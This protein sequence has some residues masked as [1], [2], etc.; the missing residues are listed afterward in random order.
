MA[1]CESILDVSCTTCALIYYNYKMPHSYELFIY[2]S[3]PKISLL[4]IFIPTS[5]NQIFDSLMSNS[6]NRFFK[7]FMWIN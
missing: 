4:S 6:S 1:I 3:D 2:P 5:Q 7:G